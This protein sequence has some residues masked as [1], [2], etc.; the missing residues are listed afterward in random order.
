MHIMTLTRIEKQNHLSFATVITTGSNLEHVI[1][2]P[3][4]GASKDIALSIA[5]RYK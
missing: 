5:I 3:I 1:S 4:T 2:E